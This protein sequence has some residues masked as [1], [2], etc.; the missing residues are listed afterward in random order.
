MERNV[1]WH[2]AVLDLTVFSARTRLA[3]LSS[4]FECSQRLHS[5]GNH[6]REAPQIGASHCRINHGAFTEYRSID[7]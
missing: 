4:F 2:S 6:F 3:N 7:A 1:E 5:A